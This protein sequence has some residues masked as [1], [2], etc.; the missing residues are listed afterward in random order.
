MDSKIYENFNKDKKE[1][2]K[3]TEKLM[4]SE[5]HPAINIHH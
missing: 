1:I 5:H 2:I 3:C 4:A